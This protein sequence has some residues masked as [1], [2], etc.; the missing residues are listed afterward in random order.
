MV[1]A[2]LFRVVHTAITDL[3]GVSLEDFS[4]HVIF[5]RARNLCL[6]LV[7]VFLL[8][9]GLYQRMLLRF[10]FSVCL[11]WLVRTVVCSGIHF[12]RVLSG[13]E[14]RLGQ[15]MLCRMIGTTVVC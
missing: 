11:F 12:R 4:E 9:G 14:G 15:R 1:V 2:Y 8:K 5:G 13:M 3:D 10:R 7:L 6:M